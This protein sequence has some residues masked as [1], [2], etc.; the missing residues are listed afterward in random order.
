M[1]G[2]RAFSFEKAKPR[3]GRPV[4]FRQPYGTGS[5]FLRAL[6][7]LSCL[8]PPSAWK[9]GFS[10]VRIAP[11]QHLFAPGVEIAER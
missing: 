5:G 3:R 2:E 6:G 8:I 11:V 10:E 9:G 7:P 1:V 4:V